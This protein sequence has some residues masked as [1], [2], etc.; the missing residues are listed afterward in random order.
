MATTPAPSMATLRGAFDPTKVTRVA[1]QHAASIAGMMVTTEAMVAELPEDKPAA[2]MPDMGGIS[3]RH[4]VIPPG[5][6]KEPTK[7]RHPAGLFLCS[8]ESPVGQNA[9][10]GQ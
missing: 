10:M 4:D 7:A 8:C 5:F 3:G 2:P 1:L 9:R 6:A